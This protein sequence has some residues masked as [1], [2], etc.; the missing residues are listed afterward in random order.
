[1]DLMSTAQLAVKLLRYAPF[2]TGGVLLALCKT[3]LAS[4]NLRATVLLAS[5]LGLG[6]LGWMLRY[7]IEQATPPP[8]YAINPTPGNVLYVAAPGIAYDVLVSCALVLAYA[9]LAR[10]LD[11]TK[12][13]ATASAGSPRPGEVARRF[14]PE[15]D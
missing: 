6:M 2:L 8:V 12:P 11:V 13:H 7:L 5:G 15:G 3:T 4:R 1:M 10:A 14:A 9:S